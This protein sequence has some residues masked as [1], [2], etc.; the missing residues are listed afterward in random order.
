MSEAELLARRPASRVVASVFGAR[1]K[2]SHDTRR[3]ALTTI[4]LGASGSTTLL[5]NLVLV[6]V[7]SPSSYGEVARTFSLG[8]AVAQLTMAGLAPAIAREVANT[9][10]ADAQFS[11]ARGGVRVLAGVC[12][13]VSILYLPLALAGLAPTTALSLLLG[14]ALAFVYATYFGV[15][16]MLFVLNWSTRYA[17][18]ELSSDV[19]FLAS[20]VLLAFVAPTAAALT[21]SVA[22][23]FFILVATQ[24]IRR[25]GSTSN[26]LEV[27]RGLLTYTGWSSIASY[28]SIARFAIAVPLAGAISGSVAAGRLAALLAIVMPF[29]LIPQAAAVLTFADVAR[30]RA[31]AADAGL[32]VRLMCR[33]SAAVS[34][35]TIPLCCLFA[36][37]LIRVVLGNSYGSAKNSFLVLVLC[38]APQIA[39]IPAGQALAAQGAVVANAASAVAGLAVLVGGLV[40]LVPA[41]GLLGGAIAFGASMLVTGITVLYLGHLRFGVG[42]RDLT[43]TMLA[44]A[45]G[46]VCVGLGGLPLAARAILALVVFAGGMAFVAASGGRR[47]SLA[48]PA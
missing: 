3:L 9:Q 44:V 26:R 41:H 7:L 40:V 42:V 30:A 47:S 21:F 16:L 33:V 46:L 11:S 35:V 10:G 24:L 45:L 31:T 6:R 28:A 37:E 48:D 17:A 34:A 4:A 32:P 43:G 25:H 39:A 36:G 8:M 23:L 15:K 13:A 19:L 38:L 5:F 2:L 22:Y 29:F 27:D 12:A 14:W 1:L 20:L 18:L